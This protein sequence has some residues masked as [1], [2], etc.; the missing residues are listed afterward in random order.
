MNH[1]Q[2]Q[3]INHGRLIARI[4]HEHKKTVPLFLFVGIVSLAVNVGSFTIFW[5]VLKID[6]RIAVSLAYVL[7][8]IVH[9][10]LNRSLTFKIQGKP[11]HQQFIKYLMMI[12][13]NYFMT[14]LVMYLVVE[15]IHWSP[16]IGILA[17]IGATVGI[18]YLL[19]RYWVFAEKKCSIL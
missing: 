2:N 4:Y 11:T 16:Y 6:Y 9:F 3:K 1:R 14:L 13:I 18:S 15:K 19:L 7:S 5:R 8:V 12:A 17:A 10:Y